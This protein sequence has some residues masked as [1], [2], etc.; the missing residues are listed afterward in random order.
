MSE[1]SPTRR[2]RVRSAT[3]NEIKAAALDLMRTS[4][5]G[6][7]R[8]A[9][10]ARELGMTA[11]GLYRYFKD[12]DDLLTELIVDAYSDLADELTSAADS[13]SSPD[14]RLTAVLNA[15]R[16]WAVTD[17][18]RFALIFG[19]PVAGYTTPSEAGTIAS[20]RRAMGALESALVTGVEDRRLKAPVV[21][22]VGRAL[23]AAL[24]ASRN[25]PGPDIPPPAHQAMFLVWN[26][27]HGF[28]CLEAFG[29][30]SW[31]PVAARDDLFEA[32]VS[33]AFATLG[34]RR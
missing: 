2:E 27:L 17:P 22:D 15:Y 14:G 10:V 30:M 26:G 13:E 18:T 21:P 34:L 28:T 24:P 31:L 23:A 12:R 19:A 6:E 11:P 16:S 4:G 3:I 32:F 20:A 5:S 33:Q 29:H 1:T 25:L 7:L 9:D 8:F